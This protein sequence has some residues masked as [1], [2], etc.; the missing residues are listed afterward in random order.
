MVDLDAPYRKMLS[1]QQIH[2]YFYGGPAYSVPSLSPHSYSISFDILKVYRL[3]AQFQAPQSAL[4]IGADQSVETE[5]EEIDPMEPGV[6]AQ[7]NNAIAWLSQADDK[8]GDLE[9][10]SSPVLGF[11]HMFVAT[12]MLTHLTS[13]KL[14]H[15]FL[16]RLF[17]A[18]KWTS[19]PENT[20]FS[21]QAE[22]ACPERG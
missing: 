8:A 10:L 13:M 1:E 22:G 4:P 3:V 2:S 16:S 18:P 7:L 9:K 15:C 21:A 12:L 5:L 11:I 17:T 6:S 14:I 19:R 20:P